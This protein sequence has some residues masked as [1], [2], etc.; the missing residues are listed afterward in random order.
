MGTKK[1]EAAWKES[2][3]MLRV[4]LAEAE[5]Q[6]RRMENGEGAGSYAWSYGYLS[7]AVRK[8]LRDHGVAVSS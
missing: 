2:A 4:S 5:K 7:S 1:S 8:L 3:D 6:L